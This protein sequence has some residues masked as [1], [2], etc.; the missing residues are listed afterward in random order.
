MSMSPGQKR[1]PIPAV[2]L[3]QIDNPVFIWA[4]GGLVQQW[5]PGA[6]KLYGWTP[7]EVLGRNTGEF[8]RLMSVDELAEIEATLRESGEWQGDIVHATRDGRWLDIHTQML[9]F[10]DENQ[11]PLVLEI[12]RGSSDLLTGLQTSQ[13]HLAFLARASELLA[14]SLEYDKQIEYIAELAVPVLADWCAVSRLNSNDQVEILTIRHHDPTKIA[15]IE[16]LNQRYPIRPETR[17]STYQVLKTGEM[18]LIKTIPPELLNS[19]AQN[20]EH[21]ALLHEIGFHSVLTIPLI[22]QGRVL[23]AMTLVMA[24]PEREFDVAAVA[25]A[26][27]LGRRAAATFDKARLYQEARQEIQQR[28]LA[29]EALRQSEYQMTLITDALPVLIAWVDTDLRYR[30]NNQAYVDMFGFPREVLRGMRVADLAGE[31]YSRFSEH[32][33]AVFSGQTTR[34]ETRVRDKHG[35]ERDMSAHY[36]P[37]LD[38]NGVSRGFFALVEDITA[39]K[40]TEGRAAFIYRLT[41]EFSQTLTIAQ[42]AAVVS[43]AGLNEMGAS[44]MAIALLNKDRTALELVSDH[45]VLPEMRRK[46]ATIPLEA[47][48]IATEV[49]RTGAPIWF[50]TLDLYRAKFPQEVERIVSLGSPIQAAACLPLISNGQLLGIMGLSF[51]TPQAF[52]E[53]D[54]ALIL[55]VGHHCAQA[56]ERAKLFAEVDEQRENLRVTLASIGDAVIATDIEGRI[57]FLNHVAQKLTGWTET[58]AVG[59]PLTDVFRIINEI[60]RQP[61]ESPFDKVQRE[62]SIVGL[63]NHT[64]LITRDGRELPIDDSGAPIH[65]SNGELS[66][67]ILVFRDITERKETERRVQILFDLAS[68][69]SEALTPEAVAEVVVTKGLNALAG[70]IGTVCLLTEDRKQLEI[71][72]LQGLPEA[73]YQAYRQFPLELKAPLSD[74]VREARIVW[75]ETVDQY[76]ATYPEFAELVKRNGS[77]A[78]VCLPLFIHGQTIGGISLSYKVERPRN[79]KDEAFFIVLSQLAAQALERSQLYTRERDAHQRARE[80]NELKLKFLAMISHE[81][82]TPLTSIK[83]FAST[84]LA[85]DVSISVQ[86]QTEFV[87]IIN[88][89]ADKLSELVEQLLDLSRLQAG[90]MRVQPTVQTF[91]DILN[92]ALAQMQALTH[93]HQLLIHLPDHVPHVLADVQRIAQVLVNL[94]GNAAKFSPLNAPI[95]LTVRPGN[96]L[97][98]VDVHDEGVGIPVEARALVFEA[99]Q[100]VERKNPNQYSGAGL[101]LAICKGIIEAHGGR[102]WIQDHPVGTLISFTVPLANTSPHPPT[103][104]L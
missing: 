69:F 18:R 92:T 38:E 56:L 29:E 58:L 42:V 100:Q 59:K 50:E 39:R 6:A 104:S 23:G 84:L 44:A 40:R 83:G 75:M 87:S 46:F 2:L 73:S 57:T 64:L 48:L 32:I 80:A 86:Q 25:L 10:L 90:M 95:T 27:E 91:M 68:S 31:G 97:L 81:L 9:L 66:G 26:Q 55:A 49:M 7:A 19:F 77:Q 63:A 53:E 30:F 72:T 36:V 65:A 3:E 61:V 101:G 43:N 4:L 96:G 78:V 12:N 93:R 15:S 70:T 85:D 52:V 8:L 1:I 34:F 62:G 102:I 45:N 99:F 35:M 82:R 13:E 103:R 60:T 98:Q 74:A 76:I 41:A 24:T 89:E 5:Y 17:D 21:R 37:D 28:R 20:D 14:S 71:V 67:V 22:E 88:D 94:V 79:P 51:S 16:R 33:K 54:K 11:E 47:H